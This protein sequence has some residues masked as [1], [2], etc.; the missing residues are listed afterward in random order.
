MLRQCTRLPSSL[1]RSLLWSSALPAYPPHAH[2]PPPSPSL[3]APSPFLP[4]PA[5]PLAPC[6][7]PPPPRP[8]TRGQ[9]L[10]GL[11]CVGLLHIRDGGVDE[12]QRHDQRKVG[13]VEEGDGDDGCGLHGPGQRVPHVLRGGTE[14]R[15]GWAVRS[16]GTYGRC[17]DGTERVRCGWARARGRSGRQA[18]AP[19]VARSRRQAGGRAGGA[20]ARA[21]RRRVQP[22][23]WGQGLAGAHEGG[24]A[25]AGGLAPSAGAGAGAGARAAHRQV[26]E[27][28]VA[29]LLRQL[30]VAILLQPLGHLLARQ[31]LLAGL[32]GQKGACGRRG[33]VAGWCGCEGRRGERAGGQRGLAGHAEGCFGLLV[34]AGTARLAPLLL[35]EGLGAGGWAKA[36]SACFPGTAP[37]TARQAGRE[38]AIARG[39]AKTAAAPP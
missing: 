23:G 19:G 2:T 14:R 13:V 5:R 7:W 36:H 27:E 16:G 31:P 3:A 17:R 32:R 6:P 29:A 18:R 25:G 38:A 20:G 8:L 10:D 28:G 1:L 15:Y 21:R 11:V 34:G 37:S 35:Q 12:E 30:V 22:A 39:K 4:L 33:G 26:D 9:R 24:R